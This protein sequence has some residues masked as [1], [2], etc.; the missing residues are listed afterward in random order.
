MQGTVGRAWASSMPKATIAH[1]QFIYICADCQSSLQTSC[2]L[3]RSSLCSAVSKSR[4]ALSLS[5]LRWSLLSLSSTANS[6]VSG[7]ETRCSFEFCTIHTVNYKSKTNTEQSGSTRL[8][9]QYIDFQSTS[10]VI[11]EALHSSC[12]QAWCMGDGCMIMI[13]VIHI[14]NLPPVPSLRLT[15]IIR[16]NNNGVAIGSLWVCLYL[17]FQWDVVSGCS[18][19]EYS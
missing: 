18:L 19:Y 3:N 17:S 7:E 8:Y 2:F 1:V 14:W 12:D 11:L 13:I 10:R 15:P 4:R 16:S 6:E 5:H 9:G